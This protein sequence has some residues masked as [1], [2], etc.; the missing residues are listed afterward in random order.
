MIGTLRG[1]LWLWS[2]LVV[3]VVLAFFGWSVLNRLERAIELVA[4]QGLVA[5]LAELRIA[6]SL[7]ELTS[8]LEGGVSASRQGAELFYE[9]Y[10]GSGQR[11]AVSSS[12][13]DGALSRSGPVETHEGVAVRSE[14]HP[15]RPA[16]QRPIRVA[17]SWVGDYRVELA[18]GTDRLYLIH[19]RV[20]RDVAVSLLLALVIGSGGGLLIARHALLPLRRLVRDARRLT[21][22]SEGV[23]QSTGTADEL[24][25]LAVVLNELLSRV[26]ADVTKIRH[27]TAYAAHE[28]RTPLTAIRG[29]LEVLGPTLEASSRKV[30]DDSVAEID[31]LSRLVNQLLLLEEL[32]LLE[33]SKPHEHVDLGEVVQDL[34]DHLR[35]LAE[36]G[37]I[38]LSCECEP[39]WVQGDGERLRQLFMTLVDNA[40][41]YTP[42][43]GNVA[44]RVRADDRQAV[45]TVRDSGPGI[46]LD[47][48]EAVFD[49]FYSTRPDGQ[50]GFGLGLTIARAIARAH[51]GKLFAVERASGAE[52]E[53]TIPAVAAKDV[54]GA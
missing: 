24:D 1:R 27:S 47:E 53:L 8:M 39:V 54:H 13:A 15:L 9:V 4:A 30:I 2:S 42:R 43:G 32:E 14:V 37:G 22:L 40:L 12:L 11:V 41:R 36:D 48:L 35:V 23:V 18:R 3:V 45:A 19:S 26:R 34:M 28:L 33:R 21:T 6:S 31:R 25:E 51:G 17:E 5:E 7:D 50:R 29:N 52:F 20:V 38:E 44:V 49:R 46:P 10:D 16:Q